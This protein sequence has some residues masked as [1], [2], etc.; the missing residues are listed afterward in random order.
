[1]DS[2]N[3]DSQP[4][5]VRPSHLIHSSVQAPICIPHHKEK[6]SEIDTPL[7]NCISANRSSYREQVQ[8]QRWPRD[9]SYPFLPFHNPISS[10]RILRSPL[11]GRHQKP[12]P[13]TITPKPRGVMLYRDDPSW[14]SESTDPLS[15]SKIVLVLVEFTYLLKLFQIAQPVFFLRNTRSVIRPLSSP[16][17][18]VLAYSTHMP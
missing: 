18:P 14:P 4:F 10:P 13:R 12:Y 16:D 11:T 17:T 5:R 7:N 1:M 9:I 6:P 8:P 3:L 2:S 15:E